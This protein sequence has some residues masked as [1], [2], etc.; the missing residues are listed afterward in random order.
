VSVD[1][2]KWLVGILIPHEVRKLLVTGRFM[3]RVPPEF[4]ETICSGRLL[5]SFLWLSSAKR[6]DGTVTGTLQFAAKFCQLAEGF[7]TLA[8]VPLRQGVI[9]VSIEL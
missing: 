1:H 6:L 8:K 3:R 2:E 5:R 7:A 9:S 4:V